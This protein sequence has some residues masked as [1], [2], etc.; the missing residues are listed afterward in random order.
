LY[1]KK[2]EVKQK[3]RMSSLTVIVLSYNEEIHIERCIES[4][5]RVASEVIVVDSFSTDSTKELARN[6]GA[7]V[8][9]HK[10]DNYATQFNWALDAGVIA[11]KWVMRLDADEYLDDLLIDEIKRR[12][13]EAPSHVTGLELKR[14]VVF[15][16]KTIRHGGGVSPGRVLRLWR[17]GKARC[18]QR[19]MDE[20]MILCEGSAE[21]IRGALYDHSL[22]PLTW[23]IDKHNRYANREAVDILNQ[24][25]GFLATEAVPKGLSGTAKITRWTKTYIYQ[26]LP[27][28]T[29]AILYF[30]YRLIV[31][32]GAFDGAKGI[33]FHFLQALWYRALVDM[34]IDEVERYR[35]Q[36]D[37]GITRAIEE[38]LGI[39]L[40]SSTEMEQGK[41]RKG[42]SV[43]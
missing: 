29:R 6:A 33:A 3:P 7:T 5:H 8:L 12:C 4:A 28:G 21:L 27:S 22:K 41:A 36:H 37:V 35:R 43:G 24:R 19:W 32:L 9:E 2:S 40:V 20:H 16:G 31:R 38:M 18:E 13:A 25:Y 30:L 23:W 10:W 14:Y 26:K 42:K 1:L 34:K 39:V 15:Q 17:N 11:T